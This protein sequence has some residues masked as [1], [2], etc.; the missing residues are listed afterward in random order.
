MHKLIAG[1]RRSNLARIQTGIVIDQLSGLFPGLSIEE[2]I[3]ATR[4][5]S[6]LDSPLS[7][8]GDK[9]LFTREIEQELLDGS[10][11]FAV[12]SLKDIPTELPDG[13]IIC[14]VLERE[15][16]DD[17]MVAN[18]GMTLENLPS[19]ARV[20]TSS[21]R[22]IAQILH[23][24]PDLAIRDIRGNVNT[25]VQKFERGEY[26]A[27][28]LAKAGMKRLK[29][30]NKIACTLDP[31]KWFYAVGQGAIAIEVRKG[32]GRVIE[33]MSLLDH[34]ETRC[35]TDAE[36]AFLKA[37]GGGCQVPVGVR[38]TIRND[39]IMLCGMVSGE[40]GNPFH[41]GEVGGQIDQPVELG[42]ALSETLLK[43]GADS[44]LKSIRGQGV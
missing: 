32:D 19:K 24:R 10:I 34:P 39:K 22:R 38:T 30:E 11:D 37:L 25:R 20:G 40:D 4:G 6:I 14:S 36:R 31:D 2:K 21:L 42:N 26:D 29:L 23:I 27:I 43:M 44:I 18:P 12:H 8:I 7:R 13:C 41:T 17:V 35:A 9:G 33:F 28:I 3:I 5:D 16:T 1:T 15:S